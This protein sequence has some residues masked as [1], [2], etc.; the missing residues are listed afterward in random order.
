MRGFRLKEKRSTRAGPA[1]AT[2][3]ATSQAREF[4][5]GGVGGRR[6]STFANMSARGNILNEDGA[7]R[8]GVSGN[9]GNSKLDTGGANSDLRSEFLPAAMALHKQQGCRPS[10]VRLTAS[11]TECVRKLSAS[12]AVH[13]TV[14][15]AAQ[16]APVEIT[17]A[18]IT[19]PL[20][21]RANTTA[22]Y[23]PF[24]RLQ[25]RIIFDIS[26]DNKAPTRSRFGNP[27]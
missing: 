6:G 17:S 5:G 2:K 13:A 8:T 9:G 10:N 11:A 26:Q 18:T 12:M 3:S 21:K 25:A 4:L 14:C 19:H 16:C 27:D 1:R 20:P 15:S 23:T 24:T 7:T 22:N